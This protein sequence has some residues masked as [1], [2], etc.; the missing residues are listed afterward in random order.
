M[1]D[2]WFREPEQAGSIPVIPTI[3]F[4]SE[5]RAHRRLGGMSDWTSYL[6]AGRQ[7]RLAGLEHGFKVLF[8]SAGI[9]YRRCR[10]ARKPNG[11]VKLVLEFHST[12][13]FADG[14]THINAYFEESRG[15]Y[16]IEEA[17]LLSDGCMYAVLR[18]ER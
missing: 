15:N 16:E 2:R 10:I 6:S 13:D 12:E 14:M 18:F 5:S 17:D 9:D 11:C 3:F 7:A 8:E 4:L 1:V